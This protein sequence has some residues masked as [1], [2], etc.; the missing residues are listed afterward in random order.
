MI[1]VKDS[2]SF[3]LISINIIFL[4]YYSIQLLVFTNEFAL[5]NIGFF[6]H[7]VAGLSEILG[8]IFLCLSVGLL[9]SFFK[10]IKNQFPLLITIFLMQILISFNF[11]RYVFT[12]SPGETDITTIT[13]NALI[14]TF[15]GLLMFL[16][17]LRLKKI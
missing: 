13:F 11:W 3:A 7:A 16:L 8:I 1:K 14:F 12:D 10:G 4:L 9:V 5:K 6:N 2:L 17:I 15:M